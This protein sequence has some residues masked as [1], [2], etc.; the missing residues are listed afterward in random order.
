MIE[1]IVKNL[2]LAKQEFVKNYSGS[3]H[4]QEI[5]PSSVSKEFELDENNLKLLHE[6]AQKNPIYTN[7]YETEIL[8]NS[9]T[10]FEGDISLI[11]HLD[12]LIVV[13]LIF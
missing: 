3:S 13:S 10:V 11:H 1:N 4:I 7:S 8:G 12:K 5:I 6:F 2:I 9:F